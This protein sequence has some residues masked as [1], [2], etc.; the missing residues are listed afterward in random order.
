MKESVKRHLIKLWSVIFILVIVIG[1]VSCGEPQKYMTTDIKEY[2]QLE[3][4]IEYESRSDY[5]TGL[6]I[7]PESLEQFRDIEYMHYCEDG[8]ENTYVIYLKGY[9][10]DEELY[11][12]ELERLAGITCTIE[13]PNETVTNKIQYSETLFDYPAYISICDTNTCYEYALI[14]DDNKSITYVFFTY[15]FDIDILDEECLPISIREAGEIDYAIK[16]ENQNIYFAT[17]DKTGD[18]WYY[19]E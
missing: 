7:F 10:D 17:Y 13:L 6:F 4:H 8:W 19:N 9:Y 2:M 5:E 12:K 18:H 11:K 1:L 3:G 14:D 16:W 15:L